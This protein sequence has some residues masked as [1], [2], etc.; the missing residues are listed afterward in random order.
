MS[1]R[2]DHGGILS[3]V[4][5]RNPHSLEEFVGVALDVVIIRARVVVDDRGVGIADV[6]ELA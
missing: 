2:V 5:W 3:H 1:D 6:S 4:S